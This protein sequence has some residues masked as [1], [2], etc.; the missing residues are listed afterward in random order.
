[1]SRIS[2]QLGLME[3]NEN[4]IKRN[5]SIIDFCISYRPLCW[6]FCF[7]CRDKKKERTLHYQFT[8]HLVYNRGKVGGMWGLQNGSNL[9]RGYVCPLW[10]WGQIADVYWL[11]KE[12]DNWTADVSNI[13]MDLQSWHSFHACHAHFPK[14]NDLALKN[15]K[16]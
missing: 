5:T 16:R 13:I 15:N 11:G 8:I 7:Q 14:N 9:T 1:M 10:G 4:E 2:F 6:D 3:H 12:G